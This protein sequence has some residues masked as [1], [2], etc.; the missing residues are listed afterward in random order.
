MKK[1]TP[2][3]LL[4]LFHFI[5]IQIA[6]SQSVVVSEY[7]NASN[8]EDEWTELVVV[9]DNVSLVGYKLRDN[10]GT[11]G[12]PDNW[13]GGVEFADSQL[14]RNLR[15][16]TI[17]VINHRGMGAADI[18]KTDGL[19]EVA[20]D[21]PD[22]FIKR[23]WG[24]DL[25]FDWTTKAL[26]IAQSAEIIQILDENNNS[27]HALGHM[28][29]SSGDFPGIAGL[30]SSYNGTISG[31]TSVRIAPGMTL[32]QYNAGFDIINYRTFASGQFITKG[33]PNKRDASDN[34]NEDFWKSIRQPEWS[35]PNLQASIV[36]GG[37]KLDWNKLTIPN[38]DDSYHGYTI[39]RSPSA[40]IKANP[41]IRDGSIYDPGQKLGDWTVVTNINGGNILTYID[42]TSLGCSAEH[43]YQ[44]YGYRYGSDIARNNEAPLGR[45]YN[46]QDFGEASII[47]E[48]SDSVRIYTKD[49]RTKFCEGDTV[50]IYSEITGD[51][52]VY[53]WRR[54]NA[55]TG[56]ESADSIKA[57][58]MGSPSVYWLKIVSKNSSCILWSNK[59]EITFAN[60]PDAKLYK[61]DGSLVWLDETIRL[62]SGEEYELLTTA[63]N[64]DRIDWYKDGNLFVPDENSVIVTKSGEYYA[65]ASLQDCQ[66]TTKKLTIIFQDFDFTVEDKNS[67][68]ADTLRFFLYGNSIS[69]E[70][71]LVIKNNSDDAL[72]FSRDDVTINPGGFYSIILPSLPF[73]IPPND[74]L[75]IRIRYESDQP[76]N[77]SGKI[78]FRDP[79]DKTKEVILK[80][81]KLSSDIIQSD[82]EIDFGSQI[83]CNTKR[84]TRELTI[85]TFGDKQFKFFQPSVSPP[86]FL[87]SPPFIEPMEFTGANEL[88]ITLGFNSSIIDNHS[89][90]FKLPYQSDGIDGTLIVNLTG[91]IYGTEYKFEPETLNFRTLLDCENEI[92][93]DV[94]VH[95]I[96]EEAMTF[97]SPGTVQNIIFRNDF[98]LNIQPGEYGTLNITYSPQG[99][100]EEYEII[101]SATPCIVEDPYL[102][103]TGSKKGN[104]IAPEADIV[105][106][107]AFADCDSPGDIQKKTYL[108]VTDNLQDNPYIESVGIEGNFST[109]LQEGRVLDVGTNYFNITLLSGPPGVYKG[110]LTIKY[111]PCG[112]VNV[113]ELHGERAEPDYE[114]QEEISF[115]VNSWTADT[116]VDYVVTN[117]SDIPI[118]ILSVSGLAP[119]FSLN[120]A[121]NQLPLQIAPSQSGTLQFDYIQNAIAKDELE[122]ILDIE[123]CSI[124][125]P[126]RLSGEV[127]AGSGGSLALNMPARLSARAGE[128]ATLPLSLVE[129]EP[130][131]L[132]ETE[133][134]GISFKLTFN[135]S[136]LAVDEV[137]LGSGIDP[138]IVSGLQSSEDNIGEL[139]I[140][141]DVIDPQM[142]LAGNWIDVKFMG[143]IGNSGYSAI[144]AEGL[145]Y[146]KAPVTILT[147]SSL[148][149]IINDCGRDS[150]RVA[151]GGS[152]E[153]SVNVLQSDEI[154]IDYSIVAGDPTSIVLYNSLG[155]RIR[156]LFN[157]ALKP[158]SHSLTTT[159]YDL[160][161]GVYFVA[162]HTGIS[163]EFRKFIIVR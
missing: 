68:E 2:I 109:D 34:R 115:G 74:S 131:I 98:P 132:S 100:N 126:V 82:T 57:K 11:D 116:T 133:V 70:Q 63:P 36:A 24:C 3:V 119:P 10:V 17:I 43:T 157:G 153:M 41:P 15:A 85:T 105:E 21:N 80:G 152:V 145:V 42:M 40:K 146:S 117:I 31:N 93:A 141:F 33:K 154:R 150:L 25:T 144:L 91:K 123:P 130:L 62:C 127:Y 151:I 13:M 121:F 51:S 104:A 54:N 163:Q 35:N 108:M 66:D 7:F 162:M 89:R 50:I 158:G 8:V 120:Q 118:T 161:V 96:G 12:V 44:I 75:A 23:C 102:Y 139:N 135:P 26:V 46:E 122:V 29:A 83:N 38:P 55:I 114:I 30:K 147:D 16:G 129:N 155:S 49:G 128:I 107:G 106:F 6:Y 14:W 67:V 112:I 97:N 149:E 110:E 39:I 143:L 78:T 138:N 101:F 142:L 64:S 86:F 32:S 5:S 79:C 95:N 65:I 59:L 19:I 84:I 81:E 148:F 27:V 18:N 90:T 61:E 124:S 92:E 99:E 28:A 137:S 20:A 113:I 45:A 73:V 53:S 56:D 58:K 37:I 60:N 47:N 87:I 9:G 1:A 4:A 136:V 159:I 69:D 22:Y 77:L 134:S 111:A 160:P 52:Y 71:D 88:I 103:I 72:F 94:L 48:S 125:E 76:G 140:D 156:E